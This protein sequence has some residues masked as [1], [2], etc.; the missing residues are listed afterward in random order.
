MIIS[1]QVQVY[2]YPFIMLYGVVNYEFAGMFGKNNDENTAIDEVLGSI[3][4]LWPPLRQGIQEQDET[5]K[6]N[7]IYDDSV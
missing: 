2:G 4:D 3:E 7:V 6:V 5:K 1:K